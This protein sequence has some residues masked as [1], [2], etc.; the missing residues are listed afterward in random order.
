MTDDLTTAVTDFLAHKRALGRKYQTEEAALRLLLAFADQH[1]IHGLHEL[2]A[3][4]LNEFVGSRPRTRAR[5]FN[6]L[7]GVIGCFLDWCVV[8]QRLTASPLHRTRRQET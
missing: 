1:R 8:Q 4:L 6:H 5:S 3:A 7:V 2:T